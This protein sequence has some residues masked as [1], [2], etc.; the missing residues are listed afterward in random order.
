MNEYL[1]HSLQLILFIPVMV[2]ICALAGRKSTCATLDPSE[3]NGYTVG[4]N[5]FNA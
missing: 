1:D 4:R 3:A 5:S 2:Y